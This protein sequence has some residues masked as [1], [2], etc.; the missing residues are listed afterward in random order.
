MSGHSKWSNIKHKKGANDAL[1]SKVFSQFS[2]LI[3]IAVREGKSGDP[4]FNISL[5]V[6]LDKARAA[7]MPKENIQRA[8]AVGL[9]KGTTG[10][11]QEI[12]YE[13]YGP[14]GVGFLAIGFTDNLNRTSSEVR[15]AFSKAGG[16]LGGPNSVMYLYSRG[17]D[18]SYVCTMPMEIAE[19]S[20]QEQLQ[21]L[22]NALLALDDIEEVYCA[23]EWP[24][25]D[26]AEGGE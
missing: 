19:P 14:G 21:N 7:N 25:K 2:R 16:V 12:V 18:G 8:I 10:T 5:R 17:K 11:L 23:G 6:I 13:G 1:R 26:Q 20:Q 4:Q 3:R 9:G 15:T 24:S 22:T